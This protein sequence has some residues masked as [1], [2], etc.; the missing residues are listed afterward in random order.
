MSVR[1]SPKDTLVSTLTIT[2]PTGL[3]LTTMITYYKYL[4]SPRLLS[5]AKLSA[6]RTT[7]TIG[8]LWRLLPSS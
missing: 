4:S 2:N 8:A 1:L 6:S 7:L 5:T 3:N